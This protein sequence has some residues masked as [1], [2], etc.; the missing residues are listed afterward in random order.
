MLE[1]M[2]RQLMYFENLM[3]VTFDLKN[4][5]MGGEKLPEPSK[6]PTIKRKVTSTC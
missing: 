3:S 1:I 2:V 6:I 5:T 4:V